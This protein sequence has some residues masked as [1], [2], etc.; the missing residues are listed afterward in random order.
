[1]SNVDNRTMIKKINIGFILCFLLMLI[2]YGCNTGNADYNAYKS[3]FD[4]NANISNDIGYNFLVS[5]FD[6]LGLSYHVFLF[7]I[8]LS[9]ALLISSTIIKFSLQPI[10][11]LVLYMI[12]PFFFD[13]VQIRN[14]M[15]FSIV[16]FALRYLSTYSKRNLIKYCLCILLAFSFHMVS[17]IYLAFLLVYIKNIK[18]IYRI[19]IIT[20]V[21]GSVLFLESY[22]LIRTNFIGEALKK[23]NP[24]ILYYLYNHL[25]ERTRLLFIIYILS[26]CLITYI[27]YKYFWKHKNDR[28]SIEIENIVFL[29]KICIVSL[30][31]IIFVILD[32]TL[33]RIYRNVILCYYM[34]STYI[35]YD[36]KTKL[37][38]IPMLI[39]LSIIGIAVLSFINFLVLD[40]KMYTLVTLPILTNNYIIEVAKSMWIFY[41]GISVIVVIGVL[42]LKNKN[43]N[44]VE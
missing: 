38:I 36:K 4:Q 2:L 15:A 19:S 27:I 26:L 30:I 3:A 35:T 11:V 33:F 37:N 31:F 8:S 5:V 44:K 34:L 12:F 24:K 41:S 16:I 1:M 25:E 40:R 21:S 20:A 23:I 17:F 6:Y 10:K 18:T 29:T 13:I 9:G 14:F 39:N 42:Y 28:N 43:G 22:K 7:F 32:P